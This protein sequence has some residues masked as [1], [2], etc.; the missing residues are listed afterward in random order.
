[1]AS[2]VS[3]QDETNPALWLATQAGK[4]ELSWLLGT[5]CRFPQEK[6]PRKSYNKSFIDQACSVKM[7]WYWRRS[8]FCEF[9]DLDSVPV[10]QHAKT[11]S[12]YPAILAS[13]LVN[14]PILTNTLLVPISFSRYLRAYSV[15]HFGW[16]NIKLQPNVM[17]W[18]KI[19]IIVFI[20]KDV[21]ANCFCASLLRTQIHATSWMSALAK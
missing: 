5:T 2:A 9:M 20:F 12:Q 15:H 10:H 6:F 19:V 16:L 1:M 4:M 7:A 17:Q 3:G 14:E 18:M 8:L 13:R 11:I 21:R